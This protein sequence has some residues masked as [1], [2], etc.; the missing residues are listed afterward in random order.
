MRSALTTS[1]VGAAGAGS[2]EVRWISPGR[3]ETAVAR[4]FGRFPAQTESREDG[5]L[6]GPDLSGL[7]VKVRAGRAFEV[8]AYCGSPGILDVAD[9][10]RGHM[11]S[12]LKWSFG[13]IPG[14]ESSD[15]VCWM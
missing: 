8:K 15:P 12:W 3:L 1:A 10:A 4:W 14:Q 5:Y 6:L 7:S 9:R 2:L 13:F 11:Q